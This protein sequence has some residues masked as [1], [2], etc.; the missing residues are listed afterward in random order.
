MIGERLLA[1]LVEMDDDASSPI[2]GRAGR[3]E[4]VLGTRSFLSTQV[5]VV[6][7]VPA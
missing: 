5:V 3:P 7:V 2:T 4:K 6:S 1:G